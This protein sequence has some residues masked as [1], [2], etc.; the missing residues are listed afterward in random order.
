M[1]PSLIN[2]ATIVL[3]P[4]RYAEPFALVGIQ[5]ALMARPVVGSAAGGMVEMIEDGRTGLLVEMENARALADAAAALLRD[6]ERARAMGAAGRARALREF[7]YD[8][9][10]NAYDSLYQRLIGSGVAA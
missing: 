9:C 1:I 2:D 3:V 4:S 10:V 6:P 7:S 5:A 8:A